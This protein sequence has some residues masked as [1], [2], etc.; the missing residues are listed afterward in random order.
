MCGIECG[1]MR[2]ERVG[3][4]SLDDSTADRLAEIVNSEHLADGIAAPRTT[5]PSLRA[6]A[7]FT[8][9]NRPLDAMW[10]ARTDDG[11]PVAHA[12]VV[13]PRWDNQ[14]KAW[15]G[16]HVDPAHRGRGVGS[17]LLAAQTTLVRDTG[18]SKMLTFCYAG[19]PCADLLQENGWTIGQSMAQRRLV[20]AE[21]DYSHLAM[22]VEEAAKHATDYELVTLQ[23][24]LPDDWLPEIQA[25]A[26]AIND[27]PYDDLDMEPDSI[28]PERLRRLDQAM[29][30]RHQHVYRVMARHR[31]TGDW[32]GH[33][34]L[35]V[36]EFAPGVAN[37]EDTSVVPAHRG[38]R[39]G[40][41]LKATMLLWMREVEPTLTTIDTWNAD[42]NMHMIAINENL[43]CRVV[44][45]G[46]AMQRQL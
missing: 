4:A 34:V 11:T 14:D 7:Q 28:P 38:H 22:L 31:R 27:A 15:V 30:A 8:S 6:E 19:T 18:R 26:E 41:L 5:G 25:L 45:R 36:D 32:A 20:P 44:N 46:L 17:E 12:G 9:D 21:I 1:G 13:F 40:T 10:V 2:I 16:C 42:S 24:R 37:Q 23:G 43:G 39:L 3:A 29:H 33:T 35:C